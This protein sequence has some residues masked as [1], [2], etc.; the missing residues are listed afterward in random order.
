MK[1]ARPCVDPHLP[2]VPC[3]L[4]AD[5]SPQ[6]GKGKGSVDYWAAKVK[7]AP[8]HCSKCDGVS[9]EARP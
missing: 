7:P 5:G 3:H 8:D 4:Q 6:M 2:G 9:E 1:R